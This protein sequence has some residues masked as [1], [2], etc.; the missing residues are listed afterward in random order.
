[1]AEDTESESERKRESVCVCV[2]VCVCQKAKGKLWKC[3]KKG[4]NKKAPLLILGPS[5][6]RYYNAIV[7][8]ILQNLRFATLGV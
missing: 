6:S 7:G 4:E 2:C 5:F 1:M 3:Q 8:T